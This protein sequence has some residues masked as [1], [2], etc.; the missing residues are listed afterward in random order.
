MVSESTIPASAVEQPTAP[1]P[2]VEPSP[3]SNAGTESSPASAPSSPAASGAGNGSQRK[4]N[5][6]ELLAD[7]DLRNEYEREVQS[8]KDREIAA[9]RRRWEAADAARRERER[10]K[11]AD[12]LEIGE[13]AKRRLEWEDAIQPYLEQ[14]RADEREKALGEGYKMAF[15]EMGNDLDDVRK[16]MDLSPDEWR[17]L[18]SESDKFATIVRRFIQHGVTKRSTAQVE[19]ELKKI[20]TRQKSEEH[21]EK[22]TQE[23]SPHVGDGAPA[24]GDDDFMAAYAAGRS[25]DHARARRLLGMT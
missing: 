15:N 10:I 3:A 11:N 4:P 16:E 22:L 24:G 9:E 5:L 2:G 20:E 7:P 8:R 18:V 21:I 17:S 6:R 12:P 1:A 23:P 13:E 19:A 25:T 14:A